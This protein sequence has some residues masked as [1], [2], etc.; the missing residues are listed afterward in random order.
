MTIEPVD[1]QRLSLTIEVKRRQMVREG[2]PYLG[3]EFE[4][5]RF[6]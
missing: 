4:D 1:V 6:G 2:W 3:V 5:P